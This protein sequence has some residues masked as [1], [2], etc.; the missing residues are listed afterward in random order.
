MGQG[1]VDDTLLFLNDEAAARAKTDKDREEILAE[2]PGGAA[3]DVPEGLQTL[4]TPVDAAVL[5]GDLGAYLQ[6]A[7]RE[8]LAPG[9]EGWWEDN[10][11][12]RPW[13][14]SLTDIKVSFLLLHGKQDMFVPFG[15]GEWLAAHIPASR[16]DCLTTKAT[17]RSCRTAF[18][19]CTRGCRTASPPPA[20]RGRRSPRRGRQNLT[21]EPEG[22]LGIS[23]GLAVFAFSDGES[24]LVCRGGK[25]LHGHGISMSADRRQDQRNGGL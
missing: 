2:S 9:S 11:L 5:S 18:P 7:M 4:L 24:D 16:P 23:R 17:C 25:L 3:D 1:N 22:S 8:G 14:F 20:P 13:G 15:H 12:I 6:T 21:A 19:R 10:C